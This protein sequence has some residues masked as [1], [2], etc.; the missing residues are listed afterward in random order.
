MTM[1]GFT[2]ECSLYDGSNHYCS[3]QGNARSPRGASRSRACSDTATDRLRSAA[4]ATSPRPVAIA[5]E[6]TRSSEAFTNF[7]S[8]APSVKDRFLA[9]RARSE[10][11][12]RRSATGRLDAFAELPVNDRYLRTADRS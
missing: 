11:Q 12:S 3:G 2:A 6:P 8:G 5:R 1:P 7:G 9:L 10:D 4:P